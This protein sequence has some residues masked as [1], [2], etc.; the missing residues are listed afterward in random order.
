MIH[1]LFQNKWI[2]IN[3]EDIDLN[4]SG[5]ICVEERNPP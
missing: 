5:R 4:K 1:L 3:F 2:L